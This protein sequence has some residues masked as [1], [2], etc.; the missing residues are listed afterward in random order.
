MF[1]EFNLMLRIGRM[2]LPSH[3]TVRSLTS[4]DNEIV[5]IDSSVDANIDRLDPIS[6]ILDGEEL[7]AE[8]YRNMYTRAKI[9]SSKLKLPRYKVEM[10]SSALPHPYKDAHRGVTENRKA[11]GM[12]RELCDD[13]SLNADAHFAIVVPVRDA[14]NT[15]SQVYACVADGVGSWAQFGVDPREFAH[16]LVR[17]V[18]LA[19]VNN[20][21]GTGKPL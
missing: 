21:Y 19:I 16:Q 14:S 10:A 15:G 1:V 12:D 4:A 2:G 11:L 5:I 9:N 17:N 7:S 13:N 20:A 18:K 3:T 6:M 8:T